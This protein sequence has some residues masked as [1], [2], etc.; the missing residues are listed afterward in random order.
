MA[1]I[2]CYKLLA[3][4]IKRKMPDKPETSQKGKFVILSSVRSSVGAWSLSG[5]PGQRKRKERFA[6]KIEPLDGWQSL[7]MTSSTLITAINRVGNSAA[8]N[9]NSRWANADVASAGVKH[10]PGVSRRGVVRRCVSGQVEEGKSQSPTAAFPSAHTWTRRLTS[11]WLS[12]SAMKSFKQAFHCSVLPPQL[13]ATL[14]KERGGRY[15]CEENL[16]QH[17]PEERERWQNLWM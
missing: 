10:T 13:E 15:A 3:M 9:V 4:R 14:V 7:M 6:K 2:V 8:N 5:E 12:K 17:S 11:R 16:Q 1:A